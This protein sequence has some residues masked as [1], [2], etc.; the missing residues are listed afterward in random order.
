MVSLVWPSRPWHWQFLFLRLAHSPFSRLSH[1][2]PI[3]FR[4]SRQVGAFP[5]VSYVRGSV[6]ALIVAGFCLALSAPALHW[7]VRYRRRIRQGDCCKPSATRARRLR[8]ADKAEKRLGAVTV[9]AMRASPQPYWRSSVSLQARHSERAFLHHLLARGGIAL[10][11]HLRCKGFLVAA[12]IVIVSNSVQPVITLKVKHL[13][14]GSGL[15]RHATV[16]GLG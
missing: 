3:N 15:L 11:L 7:S 8:Q 6:L 2:S 10:R 9:T 14:F 12:N 1:G 4:A 13:A 5:M 16:R